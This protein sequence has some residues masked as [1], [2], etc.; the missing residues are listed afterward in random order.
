MIIKWAGGKRWLF[1]LIEKQ[2]PKKFNNYLEPFLG[3]GTIFFNLDSAKS[4][5]L[6]DLNPHLINFY[7]ALQKDPK[8]L[9]RETSELISSHSSEN[10]YL[11]RDEFNTTRDPVLFLYLNRTCFNGIYR[12]NQQGIFNVPI[13]VRQSGTFFPFKESDFLKL[14][15]K[16]KSMNLMNVDFEETLKSAKKGD[17]IYVDPPYVDRNI[18]ENSFSTFRKYNAKEFNLE[19]LERLI[20]LIK[21]LQNKCYFIISN[22][23]VPLINEY[24]P[25][26]ENWRIEV[27]E[28]YSYLS[29]SAKGRHKVKEA[30]IY[31]F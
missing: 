3:G 27:K 6:S 20:T 29:G 16:L 25:S 2:I 15:K 14:S 22:F 17:L 19:D 31:N 4:G 12:E 5:F 7:K 13:G 28:K 18:G 21:S 30:V 10:Y 8:T 9:F 24:F 11:R 23:S 1:P 26:D